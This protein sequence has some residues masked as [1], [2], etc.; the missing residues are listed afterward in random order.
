MLS[1]MS[2]EDNYAKF[3]FHSFLIAFSAFLGAVMS[4]LLITIFQSSLDVIAKV[5]LSILLFIS[6]L[7]IVGIILWK[8]VSHLDSVFKSKG[9]KFW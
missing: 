7:C 8:V 5:G 1:K 4:L 6:A 9:D 2:P 3:Y